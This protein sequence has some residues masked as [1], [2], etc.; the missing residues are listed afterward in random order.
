M[1]WYLRAFKAEEGLKITLNLTPFEDVT[2][3]MFRASQSEYS[4]SDANEKSTK[5]LQ[6]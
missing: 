3:S 6:I 1:N 2:D 5:S 4:S